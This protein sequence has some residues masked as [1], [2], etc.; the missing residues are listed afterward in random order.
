LYCLGG[1]DA[2]S[3]ANSETG[4]VVP[5]EMT[6]GFNRLTDDPPSLYTWTNKNLCTNEGRQH[7]VYGELLHNALTTIQN[8][9]LLWSPHIRRT[10]G[11]RK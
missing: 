1:E 5:H 9:P 2:I 4:R 3:H 11:K 7:L 10:R 8:A 6:G